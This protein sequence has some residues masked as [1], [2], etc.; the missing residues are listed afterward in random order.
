MFYHKTEGGYILRVRLT[1]NSSCCQTI[2]Q[3]TDERGEDWLKIAVKSVPEKGKANKELLNFLAKTLGLPKSALSLTSGQTDRYKKIA[4][5]TSF[6]L[7]E[8]LEEL[9]CTQK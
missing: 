1:P 7:E 4:I 8:K 5:T 6:Q 9:L 2:G 3:M